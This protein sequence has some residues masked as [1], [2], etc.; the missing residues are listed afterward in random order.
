[1][2]CPPRTYASQP[3]SALCTHCPVGYTSPSNASSCSA[4][5]EQ[6]FAVNFTSTVQNYT[7]PSNVT[8][9]QI[10]VWGA[11]GGAG[12]L[13]HDPLDSSQHMYG[14]GAGGW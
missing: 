2:T 10:S 9:L 11:G 14:G 5:R 3:L 6:P 8:Y 4:I 1:V 12:A 7:V 13:A